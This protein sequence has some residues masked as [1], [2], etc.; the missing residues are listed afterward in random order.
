MVIVDEKGHILKALEEA[1]LLET[2]G[3]EDVRVLSVSEFLKLPL[4]AHQDLILVDIPSVLQYPE[5]VESFRGL[6]NTFTGVIFTY[7][8]KEIQMRQWAQTEAGIFPHV[9]QVFAWPLQELEMELFKNTAKTFIR[10][11]LELQTYQK[12]ITQISQDLD[13]LLRVAHHELSRAKN[14]HNRL[15]PK[16][17]DE[18][19]GVNIVHRYA[20]GSGI[21]TEFSDVIQDGNTLHQIVFA[22]SSFLLSSTA[23]SLIQE[24]K[25][26][27]FNAELFLKTI[28]DEVIHLNQTKKKKIESHLMIMSFDLTQ[29]RASFTGWGEFEYYGQVKGRDKIDFMGQTMSFQK[30]ERVIFFSPGFIS[31]WNEYKSLPSIDQIVENQNRGT[32]YDLLTELIFQLKKVS[33]EDF[34]NRDAT[35]VA[36]EVNRHG[37]QQV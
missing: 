10:H 22:T 34:L 30:D 4:Q 12:Q 37:I 29:L 33:S 8:E 15:V 36:L 7:P 9:L 20:A 31:N 1:D 19:K 14:V 17:I 24:M 6:T 13:Q 27:K 18:Y 26:K 5:S 28:K 32:V 35:V 3:F 21:G 23:V 2:E 11:R 25:E 16:R